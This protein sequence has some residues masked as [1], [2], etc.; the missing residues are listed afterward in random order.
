M[1]FSSSDYPRPCLAHYTS[2]FLNYPSTLRDSNLEY[3]RTHLK[4]LFYYIGPF[5]L[6]LNLTFKKKSAAEHSTQLLQVDLN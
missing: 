1:F 5:Q 2:L 4:E 3:L 6:K